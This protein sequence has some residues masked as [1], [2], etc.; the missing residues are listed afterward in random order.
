MIECTVEG[1]AIEEE[2]AAAERFIILSWS[3]SAAGI[4]KSA[5]QIANP[6]FPRLR[7]GYRPLLASC[8]AGLS[9]RK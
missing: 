7:E 9:R 2:Y 5:G 8:T 4:R 6:N 3:F 1:G